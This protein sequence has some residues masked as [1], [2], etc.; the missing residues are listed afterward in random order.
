MAQFL[1]KTLAKRNNFYAQGTVVGLLIKNSR[2][3]LQL[4]CDLIHDG[5][6]SEFGH[7][8]SSG[9]AAALSVT[10]F[11]KAVA[12]TLVTPKAHT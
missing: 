4:K 7:I 1:A 10:K 8:K 3:A 12:L 9:M 6:C 5:Q 2:L 11:M